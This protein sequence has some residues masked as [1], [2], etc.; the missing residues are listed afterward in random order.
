MRESEQRAP[1]YDLIQ[2]VV[3]DYCTESRERYA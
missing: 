2:Q 1:L 3:E